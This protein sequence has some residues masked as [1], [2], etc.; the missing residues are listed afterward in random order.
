MKKNN[1]IFLFILLFIWY[2]Y[3]ANSEY[4]PDSCFYQSEIDTCLAA[5]DKPLTIEDFVCIS[6]DTEYMTY[7][8]VLDMKFKEVD[9]EIDEILKS[10]NKNKDYYFW[11]DKEKH[12]LFW[13]DSIE[14][15]F[16]KYWNYWNKYNKICTEEI[17]VETI[18]CLWWKTSNKKVKDFLS[19]KSC[20]NLAE[21]KLEM[22]RWVA[23]DIL[24]INKADVM[25]NIKKEYVK[26]GKKKR[27]WKQD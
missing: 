26:Q 15:E 8:I 22:Y 1:I 11:P 4:T 6:A 21:T 14:Y 24:K 10:M 23:Y 17:V 25:A 5:Q 16:S 9:E 7:Q 18:S 12:Y 13:V 27:N 19:D 2:I 3:H 20:I